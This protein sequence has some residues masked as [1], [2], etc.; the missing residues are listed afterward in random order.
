[1]VNVL[2]KDGMTGAA[3]KLEML[4]NR[5][6][7]THDSSLLCGYAMCNFYR[8]HRSTTSA[9]TTHTWCRTRA[10]YRSSRPNP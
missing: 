8:T 6:A 2:W 9:S 1:M 3:I 5:L 7:N 10:R 4:W